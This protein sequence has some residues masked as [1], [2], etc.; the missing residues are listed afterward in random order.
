MAEGTI[1]VEV[2]K[3][4]WY[5]WVAW[6]LWFVLLVFLGQNALASG[7]ELETRAAVIFWIAFAVILVAGGVVWFVRNNE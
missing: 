4:P 2:K 6:A 1:V 7:G 3:R 5:A